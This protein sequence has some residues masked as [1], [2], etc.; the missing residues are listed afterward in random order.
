MY[1]SRA[2]RLWKGRLHSNKHENTQLLYS[3]SDASCICLFTSATLSIVDVFTLLSLLFL[4]A[5]TFVIYLLVVSRTTHAAQSWML[6]AKPFSHRVDY[7]LW[8]DTRVWR[9][10]MWRKRVLWIVSKAPITTT[11]TI[12]RSNTIRNANI[13]YSD[14]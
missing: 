12:T 9:A 1:S 3:I 13:F 11:I 2:L 8:R 5:S 14:Y 6:S 10:G 4:L 7:P